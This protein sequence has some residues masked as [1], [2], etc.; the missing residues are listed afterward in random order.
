MLGAGILWFGW[1]ASAVRPL[2]PTVSPR[3]VLQFVAGAAGF[4]WLAIDEADGHATTLGGALV[5][6]PVSLITPA[7]G[8]VGGL[9]PMSSACCFGR[10]YFAISSGEVR[11]RRPRRRIHMVGGIVGGGCSASSP[12]PAWGCRRS[13]LWGW[14]PCHRP[15]IAIVSVIVLRHRHVGLPNCSTGPSQRRR[16]THRPR[17]TTARR[18][19][20]R[21]PACSVRSAHDATCPDVR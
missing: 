10:C 5:S 17:Q 16:G 18:D 6:S 9:A 8:F 1:S 7:A 3:A 21:R 2:R 4:A 13:L 14:G 11:L 12:T 19:G 15:V 20:L